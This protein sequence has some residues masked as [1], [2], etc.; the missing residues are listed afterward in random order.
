MGEKEFHELKL[1]REYSTHEQLQHNNKYGEIQIVIYIADR[2]VFMLYCNCHIRLMSGVVMN[3][4]K[5]CNP[6]RI[7]ECIDLMI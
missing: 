4:A 1:M 6:E 3:E 5:Y 2:G 7:V